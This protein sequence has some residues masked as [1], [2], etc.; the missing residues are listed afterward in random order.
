MFSLS[1]ALPLAARELEPDE[2]R[3]LD[4]QLDAFLG[5]FETGEWSLV[6]DFLPPFLQEELLTPEGEDTEVV[7]VAEPD[8]APLPNTE[9][10]LP[11]SDPTDLEP[12]DPEPI[13]EEPGTPQDGT[14]RGPSVP[15]ALTSRTQYMHR[16]KVE[17][18]L[19]LRFEGLELANGRVTTPPPITI[20]ETLMLVPDLGAIPRV[21]PPGFKPPMV[22][23]GFGYVVLPVIFDAAVDGQ[24]QP[25]TTDVLALHDTESWYLMMLEDLTWVMK[26]ADH[27]PFLRASLPNLPENNEIPLAFP[28]ERA[29]SP[30]PD[31]LA[32]SNE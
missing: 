3:Y 5:A 13:A 11:E 29:T 19:A 1:L 32:G 4:M 30:E 14:Y 24:A 17:S 25:L 27:Y 23:Q 15:R 26:L 12:T 10:P 8:D 2:S 20:S 21:P 31:F 28:L 16:L 22:S 6:V 9:E 18:E 7:P